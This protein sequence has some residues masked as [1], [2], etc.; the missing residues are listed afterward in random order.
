MKRIVAA[1]LAAFATASTANPLYSA[2]TQM[3]SNQLIQL[4][5][6]TQIIKLGGPSSGYYGMLRLKPN[7]NPST[8]T[9]SG[10]AFFADGSTQ[11]ITGNWRVANNRFCRTWAEFDGGAEV[12]ERW[13]FLSDSSV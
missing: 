9:G 13:I 2:D 11:T 3:S 10:M 12:C 4:F 8:G 6:Y 7:A 5:S 1:A